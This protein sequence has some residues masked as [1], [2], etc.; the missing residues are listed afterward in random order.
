MQLEKLKLVENKLHISNLDELLAEVILNCE[1]KPI[2]LLI[3]KEGTQGFI[4]LFIP[5]C[6]KEIIEEDG[7]DFELSPC[8][9]IEN[10][11]ISDFLNKTVFLSS[12]YEFFDFVLM[13]FDTVECLL[14]FNGYAWKVKILTDQKK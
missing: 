6:N 1:E 11:A 10:P 2:K 8:E 9:R 4:S 12:A 7:I 3:R 14:D 5:K 13:F